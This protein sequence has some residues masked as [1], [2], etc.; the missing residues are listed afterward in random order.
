MGLYWEAGV[1]VRG[2]VACLTQCV[3]PALEG[4]L[5][6]Q[7]AH[8]EWTLLLTRSIIQIHAFVAAAAISFKRLWVHFIPDAKTVV[9]SGV[10]TDWWTGA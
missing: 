8:L 4:V 9:S 2:G 10:T 5:L 1:R 3:L 7:G 6:L